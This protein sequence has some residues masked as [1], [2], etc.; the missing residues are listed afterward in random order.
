[1]P[2]KFT[3]TKKKKEETDTFDREIRNLLDELGKNRHKLI[4]MASTYDKDSAKTHVYKV[5]YNTKEGLE[6]MINK[7]KD[8]GI[9]LNLT[10]EENNAVTH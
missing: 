4:I 10:D 7:M 6:E 5:G 1:M 8:L 2:I 3:W 9:I